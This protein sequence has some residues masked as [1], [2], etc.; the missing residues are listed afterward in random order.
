MASPEG[1]EVAATISRFHDFSDCPIRSR[2]FPLMEANAS[3]AGAS[4][5]RH[6]ALAASSSRP[7]GPPPVLPFHV[8][9]RFSTTT[10]TDLEITVPNVN[11]SPPP[12]VATLK[13]QIRFLRPSETHN[14]RI[15]LI[16]AGKVLLD[17]SLLKVI[18]AQH[19]RRPSIAPAPPSLKGKEKVVAHYRLWIHCSLGEQL[20]DEEF[21][22][23]ERVNQTQSTLPLPVGFD[24]LRSAGFTDDDIAS[25]RAQFQRFHASR[26]G[27][28][29]EDIDITAMEER[30]LD[31]TIG[32]GSESGSVDGGI[33]LAQNYSYNTAPTDVYEE[34][35]LGFL[36]GYFAVRPSCYQS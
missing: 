34:T 33:C 11:A 21:Q 5:P 12:T 27:D 19:S 8:S 20:S 23:E 31:E 9:I 14:K 24:R 2:A 28:E 35:L 7:P 22:E 17:Q 4:K 6:E 36:I 29:D 15:R 26:S 16:L 3:A 18:L 30:W 25:L 1:S 10:L 32:L 13:E